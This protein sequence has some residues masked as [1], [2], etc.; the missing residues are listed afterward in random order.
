MKKNISL[1]AFA[2]L[3]I[4]AVSCSKDEKKESL[5][6]PKDLSFAVSTAAYTG[7]PNVSI[8]AGDAAG[9]FANG[10]LFSFKATSASA[11]EGTAEVADA[12]YAVWSYS[13]V[14]IS[15]N[16]ISASIPVA[17]TAVKDGLDPAA[18]LAV[19]VASD[20]AFAFKNAAGLLK[21]TLN[22]EYN[23]KSVKFETKGSE[24]VA[25]AVNVTVAAT[26]KVAAA[27]NE[28][29]V[30]V[31]A[32]GQT[33]A[34]GTYYAAVVPVTYVDGFNITITDEYGRVA[35][36]ESGDFLKLTAGAVSDL[37]EITSGLE[38]T[39]PKL[40]TNP[41]DL[42]AKGNGETVEAVLP[43]NV[44]SVTN[45]KAPDYITVK[46]EGN[47]L[48]ATFAAN[49]D[50]KDV[51]YGKISAE[52]ITDDGP[53]TVEVLTAQAFKGGRIFF[54]SFSGKTLD[55]NWKGNLAAGRGNAQYG[56]GFLQLEGTGEPLMS[57]P[58][59]YMG[60][61]F[62]WK[63]S[64]GNVVSFTTYVDV[65]AD[66]G[67]GGLVLFNRYGYPAENSETGYIFNKE[68]NY[69]A[70]LAVTA[71]A[72]D[73]GFYVANAKS[74][75]AM[76]AG[77]APNWDECSDWLRIEIGNFERFEGDNV[78]EDWVLKGVWSLKED[79][80]G[81]LQKKDLLHHGAMWWWNDNPLLDNTPGYCGVFAKDTTPTKFR[82]FTVA[83]AE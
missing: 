67:C 24:K 65:K 61:K 52:L 79:E 25:G 41:L 8:A 32:N 82:N 73:F 21:F 14:T 80:N 35:T 48:V 12:Y 26:P 77:T 40:N 83:V 29:A 68:Q 72:E 57:Y 66:G 76:D 23:I 38:F 20:G 46:F 2:A 75:N 28:K 44:K 42:Y 6:D 33:L 16:V 47:K 74:F 11:I 81:V 34:N 18:G 17:Q 3:L 70:F 9:V 31:S 15:D 13:N 30:T 62:S 60:D 59:L 49:P 58:A 63:N 71:G 45:S 43:V 1:I 54:D 51:R 4:A 55:D 64:A 56:E 10:K 78:H 27:G 39:V 53:A 7:G 37:G 69:L 50:D 22:S 19:A 5:G 36:L